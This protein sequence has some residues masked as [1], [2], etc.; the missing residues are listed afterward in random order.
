MLHGDAVAIGMIV[1]T[2][3]ASLAWHNRRKRVV[4]RVHDAVARAGLP[5]SV[6]AGFDLEVVLAATYG[7]KK[8][9]SGVR[10]V[11]HCLSASGP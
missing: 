8:A 5:T 3:I 9:R 6:P 7:D 2:E 4:Q 11:T 10:R 1:E